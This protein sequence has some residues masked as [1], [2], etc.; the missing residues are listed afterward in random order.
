MTLEQLR[1][2]L[3]AEA[4]RLGVRVPT[5][6]VADY[7][8]NK[9]GDEI[10]RDTTIART[11]RVFN[12][13]AGVPEYSLPGIVLEVY[14]AQYNNTPLTP[15]SP[16]DLELDYG[17]GWET[18][19]GTPVA[20]FMTATDVFRPWKTPSED[21]T[22]GFKV[23][24]AIG[25]EQ[26]LVDVSDDPAVIN[27]F[28]T[29]YH[30]TLIYKAAFDLWGDK[31]CAADYASMIHDIKSDVSQRFKQASALVPYRHL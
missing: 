2:G 7:Q 22:D 31:K 30:R 14:R 28:P 3:Y 23:D 13:E 19:S 9:A 17:Q 20:W 1:K 10:L 21:L 15:S 12:A 11:Q 27:A 29:K 4:R 8:I 18:T 26:D 5:S 6:F 25:W 24:V 16:D